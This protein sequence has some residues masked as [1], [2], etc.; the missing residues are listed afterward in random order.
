MTYDPVQLNHREMLC[1]LASGLISYL[2]RVRAGE[3]DPFP[4]PDDL[5]RGVNQL[6]IACAVQE[7]DR[8]KLP[9]SVPDF[10]QQWATLP[11]AAWPLRLDGWNG[12]EDCL[13]DAGAYPTQLCEKLARGRG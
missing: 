3:V 13:I 6:L 4:Y 7:V 10:V 9:K 11:L 12:I 8:S 5:L 1:W 2:E